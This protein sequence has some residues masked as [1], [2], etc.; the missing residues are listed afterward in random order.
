[1]KLEKND[2]II[3]NADFEELTNLKE[4]NEQTIR[5]KVN[6]VIGQEMSF[7][8]ELRAQLT[9]KIFIEIPEIRHEINNYVMEHR[10]V[11]GK[12][13]RSLREHKQE[14]ELL[15]N[16]IKGYLVLKRFAFFRW[17]FEK[18]S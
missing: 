7:L 15:I 17:L 6:E 13:E 10:I 3:T 5:E 12:L 18:F 14:R 2:R 11:E 16:E 9:H 4:I 1:M 8:S